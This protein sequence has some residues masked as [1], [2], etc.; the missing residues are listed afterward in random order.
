M[1]TQ[2]AS[3]AEEQS[4]VSEEINQNLI[5]ISMMAAENGNG[6]QESATAG[7]NLAEIATHLQ[8]LI[9]QFRVA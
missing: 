8:G 1:S 2:I 3:A 7:H 5:K 6:A 4:A 9:G